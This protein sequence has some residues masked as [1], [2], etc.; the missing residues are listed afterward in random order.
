MNNNITTQEVWKEVT[1]YEGY[2]EVSSLGNIRSVDRVNSIGRQ[3]KGRNIKSRVD[4]A[5]YKDVM[6]SKD[7]TQKRFKVHRLVALAFIENPFNLSQ[8]NHIDEVKDNNNVDNL[9]WCSD[10]YNKNHGTLP[11]KRKSNGIKQ[12][13][14]II[15]TKSNNVKVY[16]S[17]KQAALCLNVPRSLI[18]YCLKNN[19]LL[20][21]YSVE[22][23]GGN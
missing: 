20:K 8:V 11:L 1:G 14:T 10:R 4:K 17:I 13:T 7:G 18:Y 3:Y 12:G 9:E 22:K 2:Y 15:L 5:G 19:T 23:V 6:L 21:G 16:H